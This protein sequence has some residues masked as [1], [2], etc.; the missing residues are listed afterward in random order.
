MFVFFTSKAVSNII[1]SNYKQDLL[2][3]QADVKV[4]CKS[5]SL[6]EEGREQGVQG[7]RIQ[8]EKGELWGEEPQIFFVSSIELL[9]A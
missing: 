1:Q 6:E 8:A 2:I 5:N 9:T 7:L 4:E 3:L